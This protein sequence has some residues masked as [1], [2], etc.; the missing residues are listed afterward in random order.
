MQS[1]AILAVPTDFACLVVNRI[2]IALNTVASVA[3]ASI[4]GVGFAAEHG[5]VGSSTLALAALGVELDYWDHLV[6]R[7]GASEGLATY[8]SH[9]LLHEHFLGADDTSRIRGESVGSDN[10]SFDWSTRLHAIE[11]V[12]ESIICGNHLIL[13]CLLILF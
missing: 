4:A 13:V 2:T 6:V 8:Q 12:S 10:F 5:F 9:F 7:I 1:L 3:V 11:G